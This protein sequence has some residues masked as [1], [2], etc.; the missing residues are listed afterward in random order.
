M[1]NYRVFIV[2]LPN[3]TLMQFMQTS[4]YFPPIS[5]E[6]KNVRDGNIIPM[7][8]GRVSLGEHMIYMYNPVEYTSLESIQNIWQG[9]IDEMNGSLLFVNSSDQGMFMEAKKLL[10][11]LSSKPNAPCIVVATEFN[12][13]NSLSLNQIQAALNID[14]RHLTAC[15]ST[16]TSSVRQALGQ[17]LDILGGKK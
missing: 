6:K 13:E 8:Y 1:A 17:I 2:G 7:M 5:I 4:S 12:K 16:Q 15:I 9:L 3:S 10:G 11:L 14:E